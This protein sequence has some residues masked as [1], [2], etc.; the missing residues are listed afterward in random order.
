MKRIKEACIWKT[1]SFLMKDDMD[2]E[3]GA[4]A[5]KAE[6]AAYKASLDRRGTKYRILEETTQPDGNVIL[7]IKMQ[8]NDHP[9]GHY[10]DG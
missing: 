3:L 9:V 10:L 6:V 2:Q 8:Y 4:A 1:I 7:K 5:V